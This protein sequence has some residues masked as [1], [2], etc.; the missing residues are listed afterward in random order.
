M[1]YDFKAVEKKWQDR[2]EKDGKTQSRDRISA[3]NIHFMPRKTEGAGAQRSAVADPGQEALDAVAP[4]D[5][6]WEE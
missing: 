4:Q 2:W 6:A 1:G 5:I 3:N